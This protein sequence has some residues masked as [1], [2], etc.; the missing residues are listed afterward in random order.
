MSKFG[1]IPIENT[2]TT[3]KFGGIPVNASAPEDNGSFLGDMKENFLNAIQSGK[4]LATGNY[5][6]IGRTQP[7]PKTQALANKLFPKGYEGGV[8]EAINN[9][10]NTDASD[11]SGALLEKFGNTPE[12]KALAVIGG[13]NPVYNAAGTAI[14]RYVN[15]AIEDVTGVHPDNLV[16]GE[17]MLS[18]LGLKNAKNIQDPNISIAKTL[19]NKAKP[20]LADETSGIANIP[21]TP[22]AGLPK[23]MQKVY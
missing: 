13:L 17:M 22:K 12:G 5:E 6:D 20:M 18:P 16:L 2:G 15:P 9:L 14:N 23:N 11:F 7:T 3:S 21:V 8:M 10:G 4:D 19:Y 1:G